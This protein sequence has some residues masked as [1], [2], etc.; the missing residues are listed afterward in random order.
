MDN[1]CCDAVLMQID[2]LCCHAVL[3]QREFLCRHAVLMKIEPLCSHAVLMQI[4]ILCRH[5]VFIFWRRNNFFFCTFCKQN[6]NNTGTKQVRIMKQTAF[7]RDKYGEY[8]Q[9]LKYSVI[10]FVE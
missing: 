2:P 5:A 7:Y 3:M 4:E 6:V 8:T 9:C 1:L 10:I